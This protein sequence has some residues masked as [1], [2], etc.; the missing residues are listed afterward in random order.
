MPSRR[1]GAEEALF[2]LADATSRRSRCGTRPSYGASPRL[3]LDIVLNN[4]VAW[5]HTT[6]AIRLQSDGTA[7]RP[8]VHI[9]D[10][11]AATVA[12]LDAPRRRCPWRGVQ[13]RHGGAELSDPRAGRRR[14]GHLPG[15]EVS[16]PRGP[17]RTRGATASTSR[18][19]A[20]TF[21]ELEIAWTAA[22]GAA[23]W[24]RHT[25]TPN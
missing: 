15:C 11:A 6:G 22:R 4:L 7:W 17:R 18:K 24:P 8:L 20:R 12:L 25:A 5:A 23:S 2:E 21:P 14:S 10:I 1:C 13:H 3:R 9:R 16:S 19:L